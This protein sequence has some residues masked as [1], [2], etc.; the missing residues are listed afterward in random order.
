[1]KLDRKHLIEKREGVLD[2]AEELG[3]QL[4]RPEATALAATEI[5]DIRMVDQVEKGNL[6]ILEDEE[7]NLLYDKITSSVQYKSAATKV[8]DFARNI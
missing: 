2:K 1:M 8:S 3:I 6:Q 4:T 7:R 5:L